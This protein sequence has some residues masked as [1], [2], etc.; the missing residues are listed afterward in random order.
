VVPS[1]WVTVL[2]PRRA[3]TALAIVAAARS[4]EQIIY[5]FIVMR[6]IDD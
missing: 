5:F 4:S 3:G 1:G 6:F 2:H